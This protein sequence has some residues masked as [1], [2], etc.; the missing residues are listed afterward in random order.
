MS[1][2][3]TAVDGI[4]T[5]PMR[6]DLLEAQAAVDWAEAQIPLLIDSLDRWERGNPY[7]VFRQRDPESDG[8]LIV[9]IEEKAFP[10]TFNAWVGAI[11]NSL[12]SALD[13][14]ASALA[15]RNGKRPSSDRHFPIF[16]NLQD[17]IDPLH[18]LDSKERKEWLSDADRAAIKALKPYKGGDDSL[19]LLHHLDIVRKHERLLLANPFIHSLTYFGNAR[20]LPGRSAPIERRY[21]K[22]ILGRMS[23]SEAFP[24][25]KGNTNL[26]L[27][28]LIN[29]AA[30]GVDN[31][32]VVP[33]L[34]RLSL[35]VREVIDLF[36]R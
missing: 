19:W 24:I 31:E 26:T 28:I 8:Y 27:D 33:A 12:R 29:E 36:D 14:V 10:L 18:G 34:R 21:D 7:R 17:M 4:S 25:S 9:A 32:Q 23:R 22:T 5:M 2:A 6:D 35:R 3:A 1:K 13:L 11:I 30:L 20:V 15:K 16:D